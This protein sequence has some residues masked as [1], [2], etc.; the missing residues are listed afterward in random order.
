MLLLRLMLLAASPSLAL[1][2]SSRCWL[3][4]SAP[5]AAAEEG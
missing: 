1:L 2:P 5:P 3:G 4:T